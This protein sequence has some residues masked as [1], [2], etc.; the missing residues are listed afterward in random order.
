MLIYVHLL[1]SIHFC[2]CQFDIFLLQNFPVKT[3]TADYRIKSGL[4]DNCHWGQ[5][6]ECYFHV[7]THCCLAHFVLTTIQ[8]LHIVSMCIEIVQVKP[9]TCVQD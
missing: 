8:T 2:K 7:H 9:N 3:V 6:Q 5:F 1:V 4:V